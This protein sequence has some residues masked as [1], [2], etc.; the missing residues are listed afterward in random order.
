[1]SLIDRG[2]LTLDGREDNRIGANEMLEQADQIMLM[3]VTEVVE[4]RAEAQSVLNTARAIHATCEGDVDIISSGVVICEEALDG[5]AR[6]VAS[7]D[8]PKN[9]Y[10]NLETPQY[11]TE[12]ER[13]SEG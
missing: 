5:L 9:D 3:T 8:Y 11:Q 2:K 7:A 4:R 13:I 1:M 6:G 12:E 10:N